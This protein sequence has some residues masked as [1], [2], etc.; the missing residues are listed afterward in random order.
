M[1]VNKKSKHKP[2]LHDKRTVTFG[3]MFGLNFAV[4]TQ[5]LVDQKKCI[6]KYCK[7]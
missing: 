6:L 2:C 7:Q 4:D 5:I 1:N 3:V